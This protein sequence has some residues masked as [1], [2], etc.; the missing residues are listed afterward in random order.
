MNA[1]DT[2]LVRRLD[3]VRPNGS[4]K[5]VPDVDS[6]PV[7]A[8]AKKSGPAKP[9]VKSVPT[10]PARKT[11][12]TYKATQAL[13]HS[14]IKDYGK[15][16]FFFLAVILPTIA[17]GI[18][19]A[20]FASPQYVSEFRFSVRPSIGSGNAS[21]VAL[22]AAL[23][24][25]NS[26]IV[27]DFVGSRDA[28]LGLEKGVGLRSHYADQNADY[29][30]RLKENSSIEDLVKYW[31]GRL[32][33]S[34]DITTGIN[35]VEV[36]AFS[37]EGAHNIAMALK[38]LCEKLVNDISNKAR[39]SQM[40]FARAELDRAEARLK[41]VRRQETEMRTDQR[42]IDARKEADGRIQ[43][44][45]KLRGDLA[46][47]Q[48][49]YNSLTTYMDP[50]S[51]R[52]TVLKN[53]IAALKTQIAEMQSQVGTGDGSESADNAVSA[54]AI[55]R[56]DQL[57]TDIEIASKL[58]ESSLSNYEAARAQANNDQIYLATYV[59][60]S[61]PEVASYPRSIF[62]TFL[63]FLASFGVWVVLTLVYYSIRDHA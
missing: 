63:I 17:S 6:A 30:S 52:L 4:L 48:S 36:A 12:V 1:V 58:Y 33:T 19:F 43:L 32:H 41:D 61:M 42:T 20:F 34:Y 35:I 47:L 46:E 51:P 54:S 39:K 23:A 8:R 13:A 10:P 26:Y 44:N 53:Q 11:I 25:S 59:Q 21:S 3:E 22:D 57:Q 5:V 31:N 38:E 24:M 45:T 62:D 55:T 14:G 49:Q 60:P 37:P 50:K 18:Y 27:S 7:P 40:E 9:G 56:Y 28:V 29:I 16:V 2:S 15:W